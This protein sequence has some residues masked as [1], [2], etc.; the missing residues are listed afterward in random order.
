MPSLGGLRVKASHEQWKGVIEY[1]AQNS[2]FLIVRLPVS[3]TPGI[4]WE[5]ENV[6]KRFSADRILLL[7]P[8]NL[9]ALELLRD[10]FPHFSASVIASSKSAIRPQIDKQSLIG[11]I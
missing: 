10:Q 11:L 9:V 7:V 2:S 6:I 5:V 4:K 3:L 8:N 1:L